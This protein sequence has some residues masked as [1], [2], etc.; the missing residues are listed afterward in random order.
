[1]EHPSLWL[2][3]NDFETKQQKNNRGVSYVIRRALAIFPR[4]LDRLKYK[5]HVLDEPHMLLKCDDLGLGTRNSYVIR[6]A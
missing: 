6:V 1:M 2:K 3:H 5:K 4:F